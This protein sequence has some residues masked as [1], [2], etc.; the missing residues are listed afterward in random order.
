MKPPEQF[1]LFDIAEGRRLADIGMERA[2]G[3]TG[4]KLWAF[5]ATE[6]L[7]N[8]AIGK[9]FSA[10]DIIGAIGLANDVNPNNNN[11]VG[12]W[13]AKMKELGRIVEVGR[14]Y[15]KRATNH[16]KKIPQYRKVY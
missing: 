3:T 1:L 9:L 8:Y 7:D 2:A 13:F 6:V 15:S 11:Y 10:D 5:K 16:G 14:I 4:A 12:P